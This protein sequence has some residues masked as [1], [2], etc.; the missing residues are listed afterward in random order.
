MKNCILP[1]FLLLVVLAL[2]MITVQAQKKDNVQK[3]KMSFQKRIPSDY[4]SV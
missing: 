2:N 4:E 1:L 3:M